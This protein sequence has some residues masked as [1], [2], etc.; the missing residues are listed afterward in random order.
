[1]CYNNGNNSRFAYSV[2]TMVHLSVMLYISRAG[3]ILH[4]V[5]C[6]LFIK[7]KYIGSS[8]QTPIQIERSSSKI[9]RTLGNFQPSIH[10]TD[11]SWRS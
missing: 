7:V 11:A 10:T 2:V 5:V 1:M 3:L 6:H 9:G 4:V 8:S